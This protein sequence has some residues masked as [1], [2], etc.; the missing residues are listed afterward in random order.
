VVIGRG[1]ETGALRTALRAAAGGSGGVMFLTGEAGIGKSRLAAELAAEARARGAVVLAGRAVPAGGASPYRPLTEALLQA[2]R[3]GADRVGEV[4]APWRAPLRAIVPSLDGAE[5]QDGGKD[6]GG[7]SPAVRGEAVLRLLRRL[8][9]PP[10]CLL[11]VLEDLHWADPDTLAVLEYLSDNLAAEPVL[12]VA[13]CRDEPASPASELMA[14]L[15][16]RRAAGR[17]ALGR[18]SPAEVAAMV[19]ACLPAAGD[20][21]I[22]R[23]QR[24]AD[25]IPFLVEESLAAPGVPRSF[26]DGVRARLAGLAGPERLVLHTAALLGRQ[27]DWQLLPQATGLPADTVAAALEHGMRVQLLA[28]DDGTFRFRHMLTREAVT[29][30]LLPPRRVAL[31]ARALAALEAAQPGLPGAAGDLAA[32]LA[33]QAG[34]PGRAGVLLTESGRSALGRGALATAASALRHAADLLTD[35]HL[36]AEAETLLVEA[37]ALAGQVDEAMR[38][39]DRLIAQ[40][41]PGGTDAIRRAGIHLKLAHAAVDG[42]RWTT[43]RRHIGIVRDLLAAAPEPGLAAQAAVLDAEVAVAGDEPGRARVLAESA[44]GSAAASP[45]I[46]CRALELLGR[47]RRVSDL[48]GARAAFEQALSTADAA[49]LALWRLRALH[50]LGTIE[51]FERAGDTRLSQAQRLAGELGAASTGAVIGLQLTAAAMFRFDLDAAGRHAESALEAS[52]R[53]GLGQTRAIVLVFRAEICALRRDAAEMERYIA[54]AISAAPGDPEIEGSALAGARAML[55]L[56]NGDTPR[57]MDALRRGVAILDSGPPGGPAHY[58]GLWPLLLAA[59]GEDTAAEAISHARAIGLTVNRANRGLLGYADAILAGRVGDGSR[60]TDLAASADLDLQHYPV[61]ADLARLIA[62]EPAL[63]QGW[64]Q[65]RPWLEAAAAVFGRH[66]LEPLAAR[67]RQLLARPQPTRWSRLGITD[68]QADVL[69]LVA[70]GISNKE[71]AARLHLSPRTVEKHVENLLRLTAAQ[72][73]TQ[74]VVLAGPETD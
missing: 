18:L 44:L 20:D 52:T 13:T 48:D 35:P 12:C 43:A 25:G 70:S 57:A 22:A 28:V 45:E 21:V 54:Q 32:E 4:L 50:E 46:R 11:L 14:R 8:A 67:C 74:L 19:R 69:R 16:A 53:L 56:L 29:A 61:W 41:T 34:E 63:L 71:I 1:A 7:Y 49:G 40:L 23:V 72:S 51:M 33:I 64:G 39:G 38:I 30:G 3:S 2:L 6:L 65:P 66:Q 31:A 15:H 37:L 27:F 59:H 9:G 55:A 62:A 24:H 5:G 58:R 10:G 36:R 17:L 73:R 42:T 60:A 68:R 26:A 47:V